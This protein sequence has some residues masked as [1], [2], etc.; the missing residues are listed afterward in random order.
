MLR[1]RRSHFA[2]ML[3][4]GVAGF[5]AGPATGSSPAVRCENDELGSGRGV[6]RVV[7]SRDLS[8]ARDVPVEDRDADGNES[9]RRETGAHR[10]VGESR[11]ASARGSGRSASERAI[12]GVD[13]RTRKPIGEVQV[14]VAPT[15]RLPEP[16][17]R[18][19]A[20]RS[21]E[22][23]TIGFGGERGLTVSEV[24]W[25]ATEL[26]Y[27]PLAFEESNLERYG[28]SYGR[29]QPIASAANFFGRVPFVPYLH[30]RDS[31][32]RPITALG[33]QRP[34]SPD[35]VPAR[36]AWRID[37]RGALYQAGAT[38]GGVFLVP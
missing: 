15:G 20:W 37:P 31:F 2:L 18:D 16:T 4:I 3:T 30:G 34:G 11:S 14:R 25:E 32:R 28:F 13:L 10:V 24:N 1:S 27:R 7:S 23:E 8:S 33:P 5:A 38:V 19:D 36:A 26:W 6:V 17:V 35:M 9:S 21:N 29:L 12:A 22:T